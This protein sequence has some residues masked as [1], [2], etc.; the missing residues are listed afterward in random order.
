MELIVFDLDGT[1]LDSRGKIS[2]LTRKTLAELSR[3]GIAYTVATGRTLH[4]SRELLEAHNFG[5]PQIYKN[6]VMI[7]DPVSQLVLDENYLAPD[8]VSHVLDAI[9]EVG[10]AAFVFTVEQRSRHLAFHTPP[11]TDIE[12]TLAGY[13]KG[14][15]ALHVDDL[16]A[17]PSE[18]N[19]TN[20][21]VLG[22]PE[23]VRRVRSGIRE[24]PHLVAYSGNAWDG[25]SWKWLDIHH[26]SASKGGAIDVLRQHLDIE[27]VVCFGDNENDLSMFERADESYAPANA[28]DPIKKAATSVIGHHDEDGVAEFLRGRFGLSS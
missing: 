23:L 12:K 21:S 28:S 25:D 15:E 9:T 16:S 10:L 6:G 22:E 5:L 27:R 24:E 20:I 8:E 4:A 3:L 11:V 17:L 19:I 14:R 7:W 18:A 13:L 1:L 26:A 2:S